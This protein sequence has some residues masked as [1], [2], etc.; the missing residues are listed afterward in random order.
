[1]TAV[2]D[3]KKEWEWLRNLTVRRALAMGAHK[4]FLQLDGDGAHSLVTK[5]NKEIHQ[6][7]LKIAGMV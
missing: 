5:F 4:A 6:Q 7:Q 1:M 2:T 3:F